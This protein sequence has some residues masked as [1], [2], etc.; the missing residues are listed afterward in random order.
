MLKSLEP[1]DLT[2]VSDAVISVGARIAERHEKDLNGGV[3]MFTQ[4][5]MNRFL[6]D[7]QN[8]QTK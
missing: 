2:Y 1:D 8:S 5:M 4:E 3:K 6:K 7:N